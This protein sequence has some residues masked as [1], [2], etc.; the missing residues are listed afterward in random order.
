MALRTVGAAFI[1]LALAAC[2]P[3]RPTKPF[4]SVMAAKRTAAPATT[5]ATPAT[6]ALVPG[7]NGQAP[8]FNSFLIS[9][10][11]KAT[12]FKGEV[13]YCRT[14]DVTNTAFKRRVCL[15]ETEIR[16]Q[17]R[18]TRELQERMI[19]YQFSPPC[20]PFPSCGG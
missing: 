4:V 20:T 9:A 3:S 6:S 14:E 2:A 18:K 12:P 19:R 11:Y 10:G 5:G 16:D 17:E 13:Y 15:S 8:T 7:A 1:V